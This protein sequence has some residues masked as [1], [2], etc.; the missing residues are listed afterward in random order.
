MVEKAICA[1]NETGLR[2][3]IENLGDAE[4]FPQE[5]TLD[6]GSFQ[7]CY[8][9]IIPASWTVISISM[10]EDHE[11]L[12]LWK[13]RSGQTPFILTIPLGRHSSR[14]SDE[15]TFGFDRGKSELLDIIELANYSTHDAP[16]MSVKGAKT[17]W[18]DARSALDARLGDFLINMENFWLGGFRGIFAQDPPCKVLLSRFQ[19]S[20]C[21]ILERYLPSRQKRGKSSKAGHLALDVRVLELFVGLG[22]PNE[23]GEMEEVLLDLLYF[24]IDILQFHGERNAY[25]EIDFDSVS[26]LLVLAK[27]AYS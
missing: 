23:I 18:W 7:A 11:T 19:Q 26:N 14:D 5:S 1:Q 12:C 6:L 9:D 2:N 3:A 15:D 17:A 24:V 13:L 20:F 27:K 21:N 25:D 22:N 8:I 10:S 4:G 16:D